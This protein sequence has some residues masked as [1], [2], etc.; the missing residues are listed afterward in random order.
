MEYHRKRKYIL[1]K[2]LVTVLK[3]PKT[4]HQV[5]ERRDLT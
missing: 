1:D 5:I 3:W 2:N 4:N